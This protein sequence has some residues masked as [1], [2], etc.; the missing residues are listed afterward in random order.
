MTIDVL[1]MY[2]RNCRCFNAPC[3][4]TQRIDDIIGGGARR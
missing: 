1:R 4:V 3:F 2:K